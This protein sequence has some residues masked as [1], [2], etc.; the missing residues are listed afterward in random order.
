MK[1]KLQKSTVFGFCAIPY[2]RPCNPVRT[3]RFQAEAGLTSLLTL[4]FIMLFGIVHLFGTVEAVSAQ[5][6]QHQV[7]G[8][9]VD[10]D[11]EPIA[12]VNIAVQGTTT[13]TSTDSEGEFTLAVPDENTTLVFSFVGFD[14][15][16]IPLDGR[17]FV[18]VTL[19]LDTAQLDDLVVVGYGTQR[20]SEITGSV[21]MVS[22][23]DLE[24]PSVN[25][26]QSLRGTVAG[27][28]IFTNSGSPTGSNR[29][30]IR[31]INTINASSA[32]L[33]VVD[34]VVLEDI[35]LLNPNDIQS[36]EVLKD[37]SSTAIYGARGANGVILITTERGASAEEGLIVGYQNDL[38]VG[39]MRG[40]MDLLNAEEFMEVQRR[41]FA[42][43][44]DY[45]N[46]APGQ[47]PVLTT[48]D[49]RLFDAQGNPLYDTDWQEAATQTSFSHDHQLS[50]Q[51]GGER[52]SL[53]AFL[54]YTD[55]QGI[56]LRS[57][58]E[59][60][61]LKVAFDVLPR[62]W[63][64]L[65]TN[66]TINRS[67]ENNVEEG[68]GHQMPRRTMIEMPPIFPV[69]YDTGEW[70]NT[71]GSDIGFEAM[72][73]PV[74]VLETQDRL[75]DRT[76]L[77][78]NTFVAFQILPQLEFRTQFG[79]DNRVLEERFYSPTDLIN[80]SSPEGSASIGNSEML[81]WQS[82]N[83]LTWQED[84]DVHRINAVLGASWQQR[85]FRSNNISASGFSD[86]FIRFNDI[87]AATNPD[88]PTSY[89]DDWTMN[90]YFLRATYTYLD[91]Y[92]ATFTGRID[93]SSRFGEDSKY[94]AFPSGGVAWLISEEGF[95]QNVSA[96]DMLRLRASYGVIGNSEI[97]LYNS[98][99][100]ISTG[101]TLIGGARQ[102]S[103][104]V[105]RLANPN[106]EW[107]KTSQ[108]N[109]GFELDLFNQLIS[110]EADWYY[111]LTDDLLLNR[112]VP[113]TTGFGS[114]VDNIGSV[115]NRGVDFMI[116]TRNLCSTAFL[117]TTTLNFNYNQNRIE[118]LGGEDEDI[119]PGPN[120]VSGSQTIL[121]V[122]EPVGS[123]WGFEREGIYGTDE[124]DQGV[125][126]TAKRSANRKILGNA[127]PD[128]TGSFINRFYYRN[129]DL[130][131]DLQFV[132][133]VDVMQ[134]FLHSVEDRVG[135]ANSLSTVLYDSW[136]EN[137]QDAMVQQIRHAALSGQDSE[138]DSRWIADGS[139]LRA[140][141]ISAGYTFSPE[142]IGQW[143]L[144]SLRINA[145]VQNAFVIHSDEF[146]GY[147]PEST[148]WGGEQW[149]QNIFFFQ[150]PKP[151][152][153]SLGV[154]VQ[155]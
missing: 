93:G 71:Q 129:F 26:L 98:L 117:W 120:W 84:I 1:K 108:F 14:T 130:T 90:S 34:G 65:G 50:I 133:G 101:T 54:N 36:I 21:G 114:I 119:F 46:Y 109:V 18:E 13:G 124:A 20:R 47:E 29:V 128:W 123:F 56:M 153:F 10:L 86:N 5:D 106:L 139:Y 127:M 145:S 59:R 102:P 144:R 69:Q 38:S 140:N 58:L 48:D 16:E 132:Y 131:L 78:G 83:F 76:Q 149:G 116:T 70:S 155:F 6:A 62:D 40:K 137:N 45:A 32:P 15:Q 154:N 151:R 30:V 115:S 87:G 97:G 88:D 103:S 138:L 112:P 25:A 72:A 111:K 85:N 82:E 60:V 41:G 126:G 44:P 96:I 64:S 66:L 19:E 148:S 99:A 35:D 118:S 105:Q 135:I 67:W 94:G 4:L 12:G 100:T 77:Y 37:A 63:L 80:I 49:P 28:N 150:Y 22:M 23:D 95:M 53:G 91:R 24:Q 110:M 68:G 125:P 43:A 9:V 55:S 136:T 31:G 33:Y 39:H 2:E 147:D 79:I 141:L 81:F 146:K 74:H 7:S 89:A 73:N 75:R 152:V 142:T 3:R 8:I 61:N 121:R 42:N 143:G 113:T 51:T 52:S 92:T 107:E 17:D 11:G 122:G 104:F 57:Y 134:Q 27:V